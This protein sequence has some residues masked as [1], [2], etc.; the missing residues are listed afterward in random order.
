MRK[1]NSCLWSQNY[2]TTCLP[3]R[4]STASRSIS[5]GVVFKPHIC[6]VLYL[7]LFTYI[8]YTCRARGSRR[9]NNADNES[10]NGTYRRQR[11]KKCDC[12]RKTLREGPKSPTTQLYG[13]D[14]MTGETLQPPSPP[15]PPYC[16]NG[17]RIWNKLP[18]SLH[19][20][21]PMVLYI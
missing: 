20:A 16:E 11:K 1:L 14:I 5:P 9:V 8:T 10:G 4:L 17:P 13:W 19:F 6:G 18:I 3:S 15:P 21:S 12:A 7:Y 2:Y